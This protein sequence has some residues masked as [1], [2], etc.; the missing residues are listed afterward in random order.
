[1][2][3]V[4]DGYTREFGLQA[5]DHVRQRA[6]EAMA[7]HAGVTLQEYKTA[8]DRIWWDGQHGSV[9]DEDWAKEDG[10]PMT[11]HR[12][13]QIV[14]VGAGAKIDSVEFVTYEDALCDT[15]TKIDGSDIKREV[16]RWFVDIYGGMP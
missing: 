7:D 5:T 2:R 12:A 14:R 9:T 11:P 1:M 4:L 16:L 8:C 10:R 6:R 13:L 15:W 3:S